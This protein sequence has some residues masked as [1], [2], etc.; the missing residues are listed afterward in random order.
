MCLPGLCSHP[1]AWVPFQVHAVWGQKSC[2][3]NCYTQWLVSS[4]SSGKCLRL[5]GGWSPF[6]KD[7]QLMK[8]GPPRIISFWWHRVNWFGTSSYICKIPSPF[9]RQSPTAKEW[10]PSPLSY[11]SNLIVTH[12]QEAKVRDSHPRILADTGQGK[13]SSVSQREPSWVLALP[14]NSCVNVQVISLPHVPVVSSVNWR[15][16]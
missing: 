15:S 6:L 11:N 1:E 13:H 8:S 14:L 16:F 10:Q 4:K 5:R 2:P 3:W 7:A 12:H 9:S